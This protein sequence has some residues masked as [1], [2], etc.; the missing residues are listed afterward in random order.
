LSPSWTT[1]R[2]VIAEVSMKSLGA[3]KRRGTGEEEII[4]ENGGSLT[5]SA[6]ED[7]LVVMRV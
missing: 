6:S 3:G 4:Q 7:R 2:A 5:S 1:S